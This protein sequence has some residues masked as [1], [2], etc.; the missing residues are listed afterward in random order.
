MFIY[1]LEHVI[2]IQIQIKKMYVNFSRP[3]KTRKK[4]ENQ[5]YH[6]NNIIAKEIYKVVSSSMYTLQSEPF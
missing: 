5:L 3:K 2:F 1:A 4:K 6:K